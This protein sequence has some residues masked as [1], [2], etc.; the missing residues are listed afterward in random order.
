MNA[1]ARDHIVVFTDGAASGNPGP[2]GW[3]AVIVTPQGHVTELGGGAAHTTNN[4]ME[5]TG[6]IKALEHVARAPEP[7]RIYT[8]SS[9][10]IKGITQWVWN[11][12]RRGWKTA[13]G[14][15]VLNRDLWEQLL[16][17]VNAR[18]RNRIQWQWVRGHDGTPGNERVDEIAVAFSRNRN[19]PLYDGPLSVY[20]RPILDLPET[21]AP[22]DRSSRGP[23]GS[24]SC[25]GSGRASSSA[26]GRTATAPAKSSSKGAAYSYL[27]LID[28][29]LERHRTWAECEQRVK[30]RSGARFKKAMNAAE[31]AEILRS[32]GIAP[33]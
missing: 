30:G 26:N 4:K 22:P 16:S 10:V 29:V 8:D 9:Y 2:G 23:N 19:E 5:L 1:P 33:T 25:T 12:Q 7:V 18:G 28:G 6:A 3:A 27:S 20:A 11:W 32:W 21:T 15:D 31:E 13:E 14:A 24:S 17:L